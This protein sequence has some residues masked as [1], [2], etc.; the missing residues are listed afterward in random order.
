LNNAVTDSE[1]KKLLLEQ[2]AVSERLAV[3]E[4]EGKFALEDQNKAIK[5]FDD[6][7]NNQK[8]ETSIRLQAI[9]DEEA[10]LNQSLQNRTISQEEYNKKY[11]ELSDKRTE[12]D[13]LESQQKVN[14]AKAIGDTIS[15]LGELVGK[16]TAAGK[17]AAVAAAGINT[18]AAAW[19]MFKQ[20]TD[21]PVTKVFPAYPFIQA[22][23]AVAGG[24]ANIRKI[25]AVKTPKGGS[26]GSASVPSGGVNPPPTA[27]PLTP[28]TDTTL[29]NQGQVNQIG[30]VAARAYVVESDVSGN[31]Q[32]IQ[33]LERA[34]RIA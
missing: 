31:Q 4:L 13:N 26:S 30:N 21:N 22:G 19:S 27:P 29:L 12:I 28:Q 11:K 17:V 20:A 15:Q 18:Y 7:I 23:L 2:L 16:E 9:T 34:A 33:R 14:N 6:L 3:Q 25:I 10:F 5:K 24:L 1:E 32:R 8:L